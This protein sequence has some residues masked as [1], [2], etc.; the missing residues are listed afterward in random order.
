MYYKK[1]STPK[2][3][4]P[5]TMLTVELNGRLKRLAAMYEQLE[6]KV[7]LNLNIG[8]NKFQT[9]SNL[10]D[11]V[12]NDPRLVLEA[13]SLGKSSLI[14][15][16]YKQILFK[17]IKDF[18]HSKTIPL[19][20]LLVKIL[21]NSKLSDYQKLDIILDIIF[22]EKVANKLEFFKFLKH[23]IS[24]K[25]NIDGL[26]EGLSNVIDTAIELSI[27]REKA[28]ITGNTISDML[29]GTVDQQ[30]KFI[31]S[32][33]DARSL[34]FLLKK[35]PDQAVLNVEEDSIEYLIP[36]V[37]RAAFFASSGDQHR[38]SVWMVLS[39]IKQLYKGD[40]QVEQLTLNALIELALEQKNWSTLEDFDSLFE[41]QSWAIEL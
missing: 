25:A 1:V 29:I 37:L 7:F 39:M 15:A 13:P 18:S 6:F 12:S 2:F 5:L 28:T 21:N 27:Q 20:Y 38:Q 8:V 41:P 33:I 19:G 24:A 31:E 10:I 23:I 36:A 14:V 26:S 40:H 32:K 22:E 34:T 30:G 4:L 11:N 9:I 16:R 3:N 35:L 17:T